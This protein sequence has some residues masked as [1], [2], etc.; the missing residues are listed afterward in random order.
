MAHLGSSPPPKFFQM[1][2]CQTG[3]CVFVSMEYR[4]PK[5]P[6]M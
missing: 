1:F 5:G 6:L 3:L 2:L 4:S